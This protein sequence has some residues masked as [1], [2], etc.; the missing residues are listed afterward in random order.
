MMFKVVSRFTLLL[1]MGG[2]RREGSM[3]VG[4]QTRL[5]LGMNGFAAIIMLL[6]EGACNWSG[7]MLIKCWGDIIGALVGAYCW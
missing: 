5:V 3:G 7:D 1:G 4:V 2:S 6:D